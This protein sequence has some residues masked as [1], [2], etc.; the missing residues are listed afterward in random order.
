MSE[1]TVRSERTICFLLKEDQ[2]LLGF[3]KSSQS[4]GKYNGFGG[5]K[6]ANETIEEA[7]IRELYEESGLQAR[8]EDLEKM[9]EIDFHFPYKEE[10][11]QRVHV[12]FLRT[13]EGEPQETNEMRPEWFALDNIPY[14]QMWDSDRYWL[15]SILEGKKIKAFFK[16]KEDNK[17]IDEYRVE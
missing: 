10:W 7:A 8:V 4:K 6:E 3:A 15:P 2:I 9:A 1:Y 14:A 11:N 16:W 12:Y 13:W 17:T 5:K